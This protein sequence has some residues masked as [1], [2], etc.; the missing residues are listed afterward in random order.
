MFQHRGIRGSKDF[1]MMT[2]H[3]HQLV[4][5]YGGG[6]NLEIPPGPHPHDSWGFLL[7]LIRG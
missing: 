1:S 3:H 4:E 6:G 7:S 2:L 5:S